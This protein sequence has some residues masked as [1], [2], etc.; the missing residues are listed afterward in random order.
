MPP[1]A[2]DL[3]FKVVRVGMLPGRIKD[4]QIKSDGTVRDALNVAG[5]GDGSEVRVNGQ[6]VQDLNQ[7]VAP[8]ASVACLVRT[9]GN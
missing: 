7:V 5:L 2:G 8:G 4:Y 6:P 3:G 1:N 9:E